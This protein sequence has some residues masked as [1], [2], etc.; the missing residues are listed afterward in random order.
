[1]K[2]I[3]VVLLFA[4]LVVFGN[5]G[6]QSKVAY[7]TVD[8][9]LSSA[10]KPFVMGHRGYGENT[11]D[12]PDKPIEN[13]VESVLRAFDEGVPIVEIDVT[14]TSD[15][16]AV[17]MHDDYLSDYT[18]VNTLSYDAL[19]QRLP[20]VSKLSQLLRK[21]KKYARKSENISGLVNIEVKTPSP[22]CDPN[23]AGEM[24]LVASVVDAVTKTGMQQQ[25]IIESF[26]PALLGLFSTDAVE[27]KRNLSLN[28]LQLLSAAEIQAATGLVVNYIDKQ[29]GFGLQWAEIGALFRLPGY[30]SFDEYTGVAF[31]LGTQF[32]TIDKLMLY[33][34]EQMNAGS[35]A[36]LVQQLQASGFK[37]LSYTV[38]TESEWQLNTSFGV[39]AIV[40][41]DI[42]MGLAQE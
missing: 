14:V 22:L 40:T 9:L 25:V 30:A 29:A 11:G 34:V 31:H 16:K 2:I 33:Q 39:D 35:A 7:W 32:L 4:G 12:I 19:K 18:C 26:S 42:P 6:A 13:T 5:A 28:V 38:D 15:G 21:A 17:V 1:M 24:S 37:V 27:L 36:Y 23:D 8:D 20:H 3:N 10:D 41:N